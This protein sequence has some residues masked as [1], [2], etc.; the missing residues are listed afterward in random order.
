VADPAPAEAPPRAPSLGSM[1]TLATGLLALLGGIAYAIM[2][3]SYQEF[4]NV[5]GLTPDDVGP[6]SAA[7]LTQSGVGVATFVL[8]FAVLPIALSLLA[9]LGVERALA[10]RGFALRLG[11]CTVT[12]LGVYRAIT[13]VTSGHGEVR[14]LTV[15][16]I[17]VILLLA[18]RRAD[19]EPQASGGLVR[20][21]RRLPRPWWIGGL[22]TAAISALVLGGSL[23]QDARATARCAITRN[24]PVRFVHTHRTLPFLPHISVLRVRADPARVDWVD[25]GGKIDLPAPPLV[26]LGDAGG[27]YFVYSIARNRTIQI[28]DGSVV[29]TTIPRAHC[30]YWLPA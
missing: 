18:K 28:P 29:L 2:R 5:F 24:E 13:A 14:Q 21:A 30:H 15:I 10:G 11:L 8:L 7:A 16:A 9:T 3:Y 23:P 20:A 22:L 19:A 1:L 6:G 26:Y 27:R 17:G 25:G 12:A 4:Y